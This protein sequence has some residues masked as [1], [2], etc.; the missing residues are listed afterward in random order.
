MS[1]DPGRP[2]SADSFTIQFILEHLFYW[3]LKH[4][5]DAIGEE[6]LEWNLRRATRPLWSGLLAFWRVRESDGESSALI[7]LGGNANTAS[8]LA[9]DDIVNDRQSEA[10]ALAERLGGKHWVKD[11]W[12]RFRCNAAS[13]IA[14]LQLD[15]ILILN[16]PQHDRPA[17][18]RLAGI[19]SVIDQICH[20]LRQTKR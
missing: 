15:L 1:I 18:F 16:Q 14:D 8:E 13:L 20:Y 17:P 11:F 9:S 3:N 10:S 2:N 12:E 7:Y 6:G 19:H 5:S 4:V